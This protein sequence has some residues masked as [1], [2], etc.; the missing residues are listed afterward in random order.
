MSNTSQK[1]AFSYSVDIYH[2]L[3]YILVVAQGC[4]S[5]SDI[6]N[7]YQTIG[8]AAKIAKIDKLILNGTQLT[9]DYSGSDVI[10]VL[11]M[12]ARLFNHFYIAR[13][14]TP[15]DFKSDLIDVF[16]Q[17]HALNIKSF[18]NEHDAYE[19]LITQS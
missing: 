1:K 9:L 19:W 11:K 6:K 8:K 13:V 18:F 4:G 3:G 12:I 17:R 14:I 10:K 5:K 16:A 2:N 7:M 15:A